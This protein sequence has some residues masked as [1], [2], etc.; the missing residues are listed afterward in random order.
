[1]NEQSSYNVVRSGLSK[2]AAV[3][4]GIPARYQQLSLQNFEGRPVEVEA[5]CDAIA[6]A[7]GVFI[8]G[9]CGV[10]KTHLAAGLLLTWYADALAE[11]DAAI[12]PIARPQGQFVSTADLGAE[13][14]DFGKRG[15]GKF[16]RKY[17]AFDCLVLDDLGAEL[18]TD[19]SRHVFGALIDKR[20]RRMRRTVITSNLTLQ[21][22]GELYDD[23]MASRISGM[24]E[25]IALDG[26]D[27]RVHRTPEQ[28]L[29]AVGK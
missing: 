24:C 8:S 3:A 27:R 19:R 4:L 25:Q 21:E 2:R 22:I 12:P 11:A 1:M 14:A 10:G 28:Q 18:S 17:D 23:R 6:R 26:A 20:Y 13:L 7:A 5:A 15:E 9:P 29:L 16:L